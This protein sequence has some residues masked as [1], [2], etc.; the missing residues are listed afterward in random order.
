MHLWLMQ[1]GH[2]TCIWAAWPCWV[3]L[4]LCPTGSC[5]PKTQA[6]LMSRVYERLNMLLT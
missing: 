2:P 6:G 1:P 3:V 4:F 5:V